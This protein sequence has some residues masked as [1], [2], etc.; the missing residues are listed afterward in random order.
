[1][2]YIDID[3]DDGSG[4]KY[5]YEQYNQLSTAVYPLKYA[6]GCVTF[7]LLCFYS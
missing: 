6:H 4:I 5:L 7:V 2:N 3:R 1:M